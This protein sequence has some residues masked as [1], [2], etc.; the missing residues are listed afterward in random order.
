MHGVSREMVSRV[1]DRLIGL[2]DLQERS[3][4]VGR[5]GKTYNVKKN[6]TRKPGQS[7]TPNQQLGL[8]VIRL[9]KLVE[10]SQSR[11]FTTEYAAADIRSRANVQ[12]VFIELGSE[13]DRLR[14]AF[15]P[16]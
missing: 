2:G 16:R 9:K 14:K 8:M 4:R 10:L 12:R 15:S 7:L 11:D 13:L 1:R 5:D 6:P 3:S